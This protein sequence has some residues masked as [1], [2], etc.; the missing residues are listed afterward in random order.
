[1]T[2]IVFGPRRGGPPISRRAFRLD[3]GELFGGGERRG[4]AFP[5]LFR[6]AQGAQ[7]GGLDPVGLE[8]FLPLQAERRLA[9]GRAR[10]ALVGV[11]FGGFALNAFRFELDGLR[12]FLVA[13]V[14]GRGAGF[15]GGAGRPPGGDGFLLLPQFLFLFFL[16]RAAPFGALLTVIGPGQLNLLS[17][18]RG[19]RQHATNREGR[20]ALPAPSRC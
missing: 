2:L 8:I 20:E 15:G 4:F 1:M 5:R 17:R 11:A 10:E 12:L 9:L 13:L 3:R 7:L 19:K 16:L 6:H 18:G 14:L